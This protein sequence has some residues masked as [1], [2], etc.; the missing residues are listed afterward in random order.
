MVVRHFD[1][2]TIDVHLPIGAYGGLLE[3]FATNVR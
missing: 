1:F 3:A 2:R